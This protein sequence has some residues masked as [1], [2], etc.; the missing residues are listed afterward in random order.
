MSLIR[1]TGLIIFVAIVILS[2]TFTGCTTPVQ[3]NT[4]LQQT[5][6]PTTPI[7]TSTTQPTASITSSTDNTKV[8]IITTQ[9]PE[10]IFTFSNSTVNFDGTTILSKFQAWTYAETYLQTKIGLTNITP[11]EVT[12]RGPKVFTDKGN[13]QTVV[14]TFE[15]HTED[16][17]GFE[18]GGIVAINANNGSVVWY[19]AFS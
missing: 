15:I 3:L 18:R 7:F 4:T 2:V 10:P 13:N 14:W 12:A 16:S 9:S 17:M 11:E 6:S 19:A 8:P 5:N 1:I